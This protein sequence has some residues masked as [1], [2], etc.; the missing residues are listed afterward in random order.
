[1]STPPPLAPPTM[2]TMVSRLPKFSSHPK[3]ATP[4][5]GVRMGPAVAVNSTGYTSITAAG[6]RLTNGFYHHPGPAGSKD[7]LAAPPSSVKQNGFTCLPASCSMKWK[8]NGVVKD[9]Q[10]TEKE[11]QG[12]KIENVAEN[13]TSNYG[14]QYYLP[15]Q[16][17]SPERSPLMSSAGKGHGLGQLVTSSASPAPQSSL[18]TLS[19]SKSGPC[20]TKQSHITGGLTSRTKQTVNGHSGSSHDG[21]STSSVGL[22]QSLSHPGR[23]SS[24]RL[25]SGPGFRFGFPLQNKPPASRSLSTDNLGSRPSDYL[26]ERDRFRSHSLT[27]VRRLPSP[28]LTPSSTST[29]SSS[30]LARSPA[31]ARSYS[32]YR[33]TERGIKERTPAPAQS[34]P[35][36]NSAKATKGGGGTGWGQ[37]FGGV[38]VQSSSALGRS[39]A[40]T[41]SAQLPSAL[42]KPLLSSPSPAY[43]SSGVSYK[44]SRLPFIRQPRPLRVTLDGVGGADPNLKAG[45]SGRMNSVQTPSSTQTGPGSSSEAPETVGMS[46]GQESQGEV[47]VVGETLEDMSLSSTSSLDKN[48]ATQEYMDDFDNLGILQLS[49]KNDDE[50]SGLDPSCTGIEDHKMNV[51]GDTKATELC[52]LDDCLDWTEMRRDGER[53]EQRKSSQPDYSDQ[54]GS[55]LDLS[56]SDSCGSG[57]TY[58]WDEEGLDPLGGAAISISG[59]RNS[60]DHIGSFES[61]HN[62]S[63]LLKDLDS[64]DLDDDDLMLDTDFLEDSSLHSEREGLSHMDQWRRHLFWET[65]NIHND[66]G[67]LHSC[68][69]N[70]DAENKGS[71]PVR[72]SDLIL[73]LCATSCGGLSSSSLD[74]DPGLDVEELA[75]NCL[76]VRSQLEYLQKLL[77]QE[78]AGCDDTPSPEAADSSCSSDSQVKALQQEVLQLTEELR[79]REQT[80]AL[81]SQQLEA[82]PTVATRC[83]CQDTT[84]GPT[85]ASVMERKSVALQTPWRQHVAFPPV[86]FLSPP[87]QY[88][89]STPYRGR[90]KPSIPAH[91]ARKRVEKLVQYFCDTA[92]LRYVTPPAK[93]TRNH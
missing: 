41:A 65:E 56:P 52:F 22:I 17:G 74:P 62:S 21:K 91:L 86:P 73:D 3:P 93:M 9:R 68:K 63:D 67:D 81:L 7:D 85:Q 84:T 31:A 71:G 47:S 30:S 49:S 5:S 25:G 92:C 34:P 59:N 33:A 11:L 32:N 19:A 54:G 28:Y 75:D 82:V 13:C 15:R 57:G 77:L 66:H 72:S 48:D 12:G 38:G 79:S 24:S 35:R 8:Q 78:D 40:S 2:P 6:T 83:R 18:R 50:D 87:W 1:M 27:Q 61:D 36:G 53:G 58:M 16:H 45:Q 51:N 10:N 14:K 37:D 80:I 89:R 26:T 55:S 44:L 20:G 88:Q 70:E 64:C 69:L 76:E 90:P 23:K 42:K 29:S 46:T 4:S 43:T 60:T 39:K